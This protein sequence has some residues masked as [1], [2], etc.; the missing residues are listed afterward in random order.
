MFNVHVLGCGTFRAPGPQI[1]G[2]EKATHVP[3]HIAIYENRQNTGIT[4]ICGAS[5]V[6]P[7]WAITAAHCFSY[8]QIRS[9]INPDRFQAAAAKYRSDWNF[10]ESF[11][12]RSKIL[13]IKIPQNYYGDWNKYQSDIALINVNFELSEFV[14]PVCIRWD[15]SSAPSDVWVSGWSK[16][17]L[18]ESGKELQIMEAEVVNNTVVE[19]EGTKL[20]PY[21]GHGKFP[22][23]GKRGATTV[24]GDSGGGVVV[25][26]GTTWTLV[27][28]VS[29]GNP[30]TIV[31]NF[32]IFTSLGF[33]RSFVTSIIKADLPCGCFT[34]LEKSLSGGPR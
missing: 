11:A 13:D 27:G 22:A 10:Q 9:P 25:R 8:V 33:E 20:L 4:P 16:N 6:S 3:W 24:E 1:A 15:K 28:V 2:G 21:L 7:R 31:T 12:Q 5:L 19:D 18:D 30:D 14:Q 29:V 26:D 23:R 17:E 32:S 34:G